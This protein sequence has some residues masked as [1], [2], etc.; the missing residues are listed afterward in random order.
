M[1]LKKRGFQGLRMGSYLMMLY[2]TEQQEVALKSF[3]GEQGWPFLKPDLSATTEKLGGLVEK[4]EATTTSISMRPVR[5]M[6]RKRKAAATATAQS[7]VKAPVVK[8]AKVVPST[9]IITVP[10]FGNMAADGTERSPSPEQE[11]NILVKTEASDDDDDENDYNNDIDNGDNDDDYGVS[12]TENL[13]SVQDAEMEMV[14]AIVAAGQTM[15]EDTSQAKGRGRRIRKSGSVKAGKQYSCD[16]CDRE[17][18]SA[19]G[20]RRHRMRHFPNAKRFQCIECGKRFFERRD[21][22]EHMKTHN[23]KDSKCTYC[24]K[25]CHDLADH[26]ERCSKFLKSKS[27]LKCRGCQMNFNNEE[28][29]NAHIE[30]CYIPDYQCHICGMKFTAS[31]TLKDHVER[32]SAKKKELECDVCHKKFRVQ[33]DLTKHKRTHEPEA[34][35]KSCGELVPGGYH[36]PRQCPVKASKNPKYKC[37]YCAVTING[38]L[39]HILRHINR[40]HG[41]AAEKEFASQYGEETRGL[42]KC[43]ECGYFFKGNRKALERHIEM[44][45]K[46][47]TVIPCEGC[48]DTFRTKLELLVHEKSCPANAAD[49][50]K[51][52]QRLIPKVIYQCSNCS[53][54]HYTKADHNKHVEEC[55]HTPQVQE[56]EAEAVA[57][58]TG[59]GQVCYIV[60][61]QD[62]QQ[63]IVPATSLSADNMQVYVEHW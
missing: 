25:F 8:Q 28:D 44:Y 45:H 41:A 59:L 6:T 16:M 58:E 7:P 39:S 14:E 36:N 54:I 42:R 43:N 19:S 1:F 12:E 2:V 57:A 21:L 10:L 23:L 60:T 5:E 56:V 50:G 17:C 11:Q 49:D 48:E 22:M 55:A 20:L 62:G 53:T 40:K 47:N 51:S 15:T 26:Y 30:S 63:T 52:P 46:D 34:Q 31:A 29:Y 38:S 4:E 9:N 18:T 61:E 37:P 33:L 24:G 35:C 3:F 13:L 27:I 32:H